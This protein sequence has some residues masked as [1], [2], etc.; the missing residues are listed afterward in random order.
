MRNSASHLGSE[1]NAFLFAPIGEGRNG[2]L[3]SV[4]SVLA[5]QDID[6]WG[7]AAE[8]ASLPRENAIRR[9]SSLIAEI[10]DELPAS[11]DV[12]TVATR[13]IALLPRSPKFNASP[14]IEPSGPSFLAN[15]RSAIA[16]M[17]FMAVVL[18]AQ[19]F[20]ANRFESTQ[21]RPPH[22]SS[23]SVVT[24]KSLSQNSRP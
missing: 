5:R 16:M 24:S 22:L 18:A 7:E 2:M 17:I 19:A 6:P 21:I 8:L 13:L 15:S 12:P 1:F 10:P 3:L 14:R 11:H 4:L 23:A 9:L 20:L